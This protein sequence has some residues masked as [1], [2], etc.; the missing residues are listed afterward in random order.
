MATLVSGL[1][2]AA[3]CALA[4]AVAR[5]TS[6]LAPH[7]ITL[8]DRRQTKG[9]APE[10]ADPLDRQHASPDQRL[11]ES[12][13]RPVL[14]LALAAGLAL[15]FVVVRFALAFVPLPLPCSGIL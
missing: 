7:A 1:A 8:P 5:L 13:L 3:P 4:F 6:R 14:A 11:I 15:A 2:I 12:R 9:P 10:D